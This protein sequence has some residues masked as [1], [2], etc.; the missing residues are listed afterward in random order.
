[1]TH[2]CDKNEVIS[3]IEKTLPDTQAIDRITVF[4]NPEFLR[5]FQIA[6]HHQ[7]KDSFHNEVK[8]F[9]SV[10]TNMQCMLKGVCAQ[11]LQWQIDP[12]TG[13]RKKAVFACSW[14]DQPLEL[15]DFDHYAERIL[16]NKM[17]ETL[18]QLWLNY[19]ESEPEDE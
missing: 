16:Q 5:S 15:I 9:G 11:C 10:H 19:I 7:L 13:K 18:S 12:E 14:Q 8:I 17:A 1:V 4:G 6:R 3:I 2:W